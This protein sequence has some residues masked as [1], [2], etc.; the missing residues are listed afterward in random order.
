[1]RCKIIYLLA[2]LTSAFAF[3]AYPQ[4]NT[5]QVMRVGQNVLYFED[6]V[7]SIQYFNQA[8][9]S[10]PYLA[11]PYLYRAIAKVNLDDYRG[12]EADA[13]KALELNPFLTDAWEV[14]GVARQNLGRD[15]EAIDDYREALKL[16]P[17]NRQIM[18]N[19][20]LA[21]SDIKHYEEA[22][23]TF[24]DLL[25]YYPGFANG[26][27]GRARLNLALADTVAASA[28]IEKALSIDQNLL[29]AYLMRASIAIDQKR[30]YDQALADM[31]RAAKLEPRLAGLYINR[32][33][34]RYML[35]DYFGAMADYDYALELE[36]LNTTALFNRSLLLMEVGDNDRALADLS[37]ILRLDP[38]EYRAR[39]NRAVVN[40]LKH[41]FA[42]AIADIDMVI[43]QFPDFSSA[44]YM[45]SE[46]LRESGKLAQAKADYD[47][48]LALAKAAVNSE[49]AEVESAPEELKPEEASR[50]F[51]TLLT[52]DTETPLSEEYNNS[53]IHG[54]V[55]DRNLTIEIEPLME[56][57]YYSSPTELKPNTY[58]IKEVDDI[59]A[60]RM[61]RFVIVV[62]S[63]PPQL[64]DEAMIQR[65][66]TSIE[67]YNSYLAT[68]TPRAI[69]YLGRALDFI[70]VKNYDAA[71]AD[72]DRAAELTPDQP[73]I[74]LL[75]AQARYHQRPE[76]TDGNKMLG[77]PEA[78]PSNLALVLRD[79]DKALELSP[80]SAVAWF[81]KG[82]ILFELGDFTSAIAAYNQAI[83]LE[84]EMGEAFY[85][86]GYVHLKLGN[87]RA[88]IADL[89]KA[90]ELGIVSAYNL[91][92][93]ISKN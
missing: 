92:K 31:N 30:D 25:T 22:D 37:R 59:N 66:F 36:P 13:T 45:R 19:M 68:H 6:Y 4:I 81:D 7:L 91:I 85:N 2:L 24:R 3:H 62:T 39:Y 46:F 49:A 10:K 90:G 77:M 32:A 20:A 58:Y 64:N 87:Q 67:Y 48:G 51:N 61:L 8:I 27:M 69:D 11:Q 63:N 54:R 93:R 83:A 5:E 78:M 17:R 34:L 38:T 57:S 50:R 71:I 14:R 88:G 72:L 65:H 73:V 40:G 33:Y 9:Q 70:T 29:N 21:L 52:I 26:Y 84:P 76:P 35:D 74:Y 12:A 1:M 42:D 23:S 79:L 15:V 75:R 41:N 89:S 47:K 43:D 82:N 56:L 86:R 60:T 55:Q 28:D 53:A 44:Y 18:F 16:L 80:R